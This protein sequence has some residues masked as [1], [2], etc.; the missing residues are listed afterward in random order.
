MQIQ[1]ILDYRSPYAYLANTQIMSMGV[2]IKYEPVE[3]V[4]VMKRV[5]NQPSP[6]CPPNE[7]RRSRRGTVGE[8]LRRALFT[9]QTAA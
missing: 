7:I 3:I 2:Q 6:M 5:N 8:A 1:F 4:S 9:Q